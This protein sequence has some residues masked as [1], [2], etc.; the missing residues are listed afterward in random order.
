[1]DSNQTIDLIYDFCNKNPRDYTYFAVGSSP[2]VLEI[3]KFTPKLDQIFPTFLRNVLNTTS[4]TIRVIHYDPMFIEEHIITFLKEYFKS[5]PYD[6]KFNDSDGFLSWKTLDHRIEVF[7]IGDNFNIPEETNHIELIIKHHLK[8]NT[9]LVF[10]EYYGLSNSSTSLVQMHQKFY[11]NIISPELKER[12]KHN[13]LFDIT[14]GEAHCSTDMSKEEPIVDDYGNFI[15]LCILNPKEKLDL[16][17]INPNPKFNDIYK[18]LCIQQFI[19][20]LDNEHVEYRRS[21]NNKLSSE[22]SDSIMAT[23]I[24]KMKP[25]LNI[26][27]KIQ[28][29]N[30]SDMEKINNLLYNYKT[31]NMYSWSFE[32]KN[33]II[34]KN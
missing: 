19:D 22:I 11:N 28:V 33:I 24:L 16:I 21:I 9:K 27:I 5:L 30:D 18:N 3:D 29:L 8:T 25:I 10:Q 1:M 34:K 23:I 4:A 32:L 13:I 12:Y 15:N 17:D 26:L 7:I 14:Y 6:F 20:I 2:G 31:I